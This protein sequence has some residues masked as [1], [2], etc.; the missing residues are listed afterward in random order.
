[1]PLYKSY[2]PN[3]STTV[4]VW[5]ISE[6]YKE[7]ISSIFLSK[8]SL[9]KLENIKS[10]NKKCELLSVRYLLLEFGY[11]DKDLYYNES[12]KPLLIDGKNISISHSTLFSV[13]IVSDLNISVDIEKVSDKILNV[14]DKF[15]DYEY[16]YLSDLNPEK[17]R[18]TYIW[19]IKECIYKISPSKLP[20]IFKDKCIVLPFSVNDSLV[21]S[22]LKFNDLINSY[23]SYLHNFEGYNLVYLTKEK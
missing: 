17:M 9:K 5:K 4:K 8:L 20:Y 11:S 21:I 7:L 6:S 22:W 19:C 14:S 2:S 15:I 3:I 23:N 13:I 10:E 1:M 18:L 12:G 16:T